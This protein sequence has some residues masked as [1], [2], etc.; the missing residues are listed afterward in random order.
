MPDSDG[1]RLDIACADQLSESDPCARRDGDHA[2]TD[3]RCVT[4]AN[5]AE[6]PTPAGAK[7][8]EPPTAEAEPRAEIAELLTWLAAAREAIATFNAIRAIAFDDTPLPHAAI[9]EIRSRYQEFDAKHPQ[10][11][12]GTS[13]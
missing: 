12:K 7:T 5:P 4:C 2:I 13:S 10:L 1:F 9:R 6:P 3:G 8:P 11:T